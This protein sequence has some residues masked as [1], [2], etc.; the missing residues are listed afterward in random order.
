M[1]KY[2]IK[3][4]QTPLPYDEKRRRAYASET[5]PLLGQVLRGEVSLEEYKYKVEEIKTRYP[6]E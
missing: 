1:A 2:F 6:K 3:S 5:D 4:N